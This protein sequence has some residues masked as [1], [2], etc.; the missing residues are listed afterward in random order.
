[1]ACKIKICGLTRIDDIIAVNEAR[2]DYIGFVFAESRRRISPENARRLRAALAPG[3]G[4][5][6][7]FVNPD[8]AEVLA[9]TKAGI[10]DLI[11]LH[12]T[13][14]EDMIRW[15]QE[16]TGR[17]V[18]KAVS[19]TGR[20]SLAAWRTSAADY[21]LFDNGAGG[22]GK[23]FDWTLAQGERRPFFLAGGLCEDNIPAAMGLS[24]YCLDVS[25]GAETDG[26]K[27][28]EK[29]RRIV[30]MIRCGS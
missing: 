26:V 16:K 27:D 22:T 20:S 23:T 4:A 18:I 29:I 8:P 13:E 14:D 15:I 30:A 12:G 17:Q 11:Q 28:R 2:P 21:L 6:G 19:V 3:I 25:S 5:V 7:V 24:P 1:M 9:V 10:I